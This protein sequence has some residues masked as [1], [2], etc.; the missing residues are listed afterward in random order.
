MTVNSMVPA[1]IHTLPPL[2]KEQPPLPDASSETNTNELSHKRPV[3]END[4]L[5]EMEQSPSK[6]GRYIGL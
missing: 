2:A 1:L 5:H 4:S 3:P 6:K